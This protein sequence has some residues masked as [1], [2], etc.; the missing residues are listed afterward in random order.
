M[1]KSATTIEPIHPGEVLR[2]EFLEPMGLSANELA[3]RIEV[4]GNRI[5]AIVA[6]K[7]G[8]TGDTALRLAAAFGTSPEFWLGLQQ[9]WDLEK[10]RD[11]ARSMDFA[12]LRVDK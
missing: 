9:R 8:V 5:S 11:A 7:R 1:S 2:H 4:P 6:R 12:R 10:A 3:R